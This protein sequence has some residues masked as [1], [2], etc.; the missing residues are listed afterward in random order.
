MILLGISQISTFEQSDFAFHRFSMNIR[1]Y[2]EIF[3]KIVLATPDNSWLLED[4]AHCH[5]TSSQDGDPG[6]GV[7][8]QTVCNFQFCN[9]QLDLFNPASS[10]SR[11]VF[12]SIVLSA[13]KT[14]TA[15]ANTNTKVVGN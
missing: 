2:W 4:R 11:E 7:E 12:A 5:E 8:S 6:Y 10:E 15:T 1:H 13:N 3:D 14:T 9:I